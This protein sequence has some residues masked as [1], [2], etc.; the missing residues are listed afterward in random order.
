MSTNY[1]N[2]VRN[3][4]VENLSI[5]FQKMWIKHISRENKKAYKL[6]LKILIKTIIR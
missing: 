2:L 3:L 4:F 5:S 1:E 6:E